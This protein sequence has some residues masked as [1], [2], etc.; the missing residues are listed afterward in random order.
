MFHVPNNWRVR[1]H[2]DLASSDADGNN[3]MFVIPAGLRRPMAMRCVASD[4]I[5]WE[6]VSVSVSGRCPTWE[7][8][9]YVKSVFWDPEDVVLQY[10]P[11]ESD[12]V[13]NHPYCLHLWRPIGV[14]IPTPPSIAVGVL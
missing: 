3:G 4:G 10:H 5:G 1:G 11:R 2:H 7:E 6:H 14:V 8:M 12:Y 9:C 13:N